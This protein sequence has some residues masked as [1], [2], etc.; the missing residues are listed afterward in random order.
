[1]PTKSKTVVRAFASSNDAGEIVEGRHHARE[2]ESYEIC[3]IIVWAVCIR[4]VPR[5]LATPEGVPVGELEECQSGLDFPGR[6]KGLEWCH[7]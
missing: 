1:M 6:P 5:M 2:E 7:G 3:L 4:G